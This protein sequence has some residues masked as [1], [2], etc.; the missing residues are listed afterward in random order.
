MRGRYRVAA[1]PQT[2]LALVAVFILST[3]S[4][5]QLRN[6]VETARRAE[7]REVEL[8]AA[9]VARRHLAQITELGFDEADAGGTDLRLSTA[10]LTGV[11]GL[12]PDAGESMASN[13]DDVD[14]FHLPAGTAVAD[15]VLWDGGMIR[16][17]VSTSVRYI[18][19]AAQAAAAAPTLLKEI[20]VTVRE[21]N[22]AAAARP[23]ATARLRA[24]VSAA[25]LRPV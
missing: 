11:A 13:Y 2:F 17:D 3:Y 10:G 21:R 5:S 23:P 19:A 25:A 16:F 4:L 20:V 8:A 6:T 1:M 15:S 22:S 14:D 7:Q 18:D 12:G 9:D 24:V